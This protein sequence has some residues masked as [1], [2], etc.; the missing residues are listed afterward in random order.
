[1][2]MDKAS[3]LLAGLVALQGCAYVSAT[4]IITDKPLT[5]DVK[6]YGIRYWLARP[7]LLV[8]R[9]VEIVREDTYSLSLDGQ[10]FTK[11]TFEQAMQAVEEAR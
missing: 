10:A 2:Q 7:Y 8:S 3:A 11:I 9:P 5:E 1:M 6:Q 4:R